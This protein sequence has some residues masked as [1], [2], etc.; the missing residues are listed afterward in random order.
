M[1]VFTEISPKHLMQ[2]FGLDSY[3]AARKRA[4]AIRNEYKTKVLTVYHLALYLNLPESK[5]LEGIR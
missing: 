5:V 3:E 4:V 1:S 2:F